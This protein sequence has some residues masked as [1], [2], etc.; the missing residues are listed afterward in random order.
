M[1]EP[2]FDL[3]RA[4]LRFDADDEVLARAA[5]SRLAEPGDAVAGALVDSLGPAD[6]LRW[7]VD[8]AGAPERAEA[9]LRRIA[10]GREL[11][12]GTVDGSPGLAEAPGRLPEVSTGAATGEGPAAGRA[13]RGGAVG[14]LVAAVRRWAPRLERL[15]PEGELAVLGRHGGT[16]LAPGDPRWPSSFDVLGAA[17]PLC[18]WVRGDPDLARLARRS[19]SLV[20]SRACTDYGVRVARSLARGLAERGFTLVSGG[21]A[22]IDAEVHRGALVSGAPTVAFLAGGVDRLYPASSTD[23]LRRAAEEGGAVVSE[24]PPGSVPGKQRFLKRNRLIA[25][26]SS[27][28]VVVEAALRSGALST[29]NHAVRLLRPLGAVPG[30]VTSMAS[31]GC[32]ELLRRGAAVCVT[33]AAEAAELVGDMGEAAPVRRGESRPGDDLD[34]ASAAVLDALPVRKPAHE[35]SIARVAGLAFADTTGALGLLELL[36]LAEQRDGGW[37]RR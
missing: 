11:G 25:A 17:A 31:A 30:P 35:R 14:L 18:L 6:A 23:L 19:V 13:A 34:A 2:L 9:V 22:G 36:G 12:L 15:D 3:P 1:D 8:A 10:G 29:A 24:A 21:A 27:G 4:G 26:L 5:W 7:L 37:R 16:F 32:H 33:D 28:T 20:G